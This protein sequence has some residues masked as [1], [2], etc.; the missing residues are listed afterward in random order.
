MYTDAIIG[1]NEYKNAAHNEVVFMSHKRDVKICP[2]IRLIN[3]SNI[4]GKKEDKS[5]IH[6]TYWHLVKQLNII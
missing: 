5:E 6:V 2:S 1:N 4:S 3:F